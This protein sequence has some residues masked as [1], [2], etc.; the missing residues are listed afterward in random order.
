[1]KVNKKKP[2][3]VLRKDV[4]KAPVKKVQ[5]SVPFLKPLPPNIAK[6]TDGLIK[7]AIHAA[8]KKLLK[9]ATPGN[10][11]TAEKNLWKWF[12]DVF[13]MIGMRESPYAQ[14]PLQMTRIENRV[15][16]GRPDVD[17]CYR[18]KCAILELKSVEDGELIKTGLTTT[19][20]MYLHRRHQIGGSAW[21]LIQVGSATRYLI[22]GKHAPELVGRVPEK[23][24]AKFA[25]PLLFGDQCEI[26]DRITGQ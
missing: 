2:V 24:L 19:Q 9:P 3:T 17:I 11:K 16:T 10:T 21:L 1:M 4:K 5:K 20:A 18:G 8:T 14:P 23:L 6:K 7:K 26:L 15:S 22:C 12:K 13:Q 25:E